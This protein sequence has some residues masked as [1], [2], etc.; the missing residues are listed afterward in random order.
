[1]LGGRSVHFQIA[2]V[3]DDEAAG[4]VEHHDA[5]RHVVE[6]ELEQAALVVQP[7]VGE[8]A[9]I[10]L[11]PRIATAMLAMASASESGDSDSAVIARVG[12]GTMS[13][14]PMATK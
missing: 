1:M 8:S 4:R 5:L 7:A 14:A 10:R 3:A 12:S 13:T 6:R 2:L 9:A 11:M